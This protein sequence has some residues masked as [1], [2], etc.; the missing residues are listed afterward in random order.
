MI[1]ARSPRG[2]NTIMGTLIG[3]SRDSGV[4]RFDFRN[5]P[6]FERGSLA[7][8]RGDVFTVGPNAI[9]FRLSGRLG[10]SVEFTYELRP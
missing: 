4:W 1:D 2:V 3:G 10:E 6:R 5:E 9:V 8:V 7:I